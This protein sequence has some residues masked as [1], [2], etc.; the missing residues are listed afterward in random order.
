MYFR[1]WLSVLLLSSHAFTLEM[2]A[3]NLKG[4]SAAKSYL[5]GLAALPN[6]NS[7]KASYEQT[8]LHFEKAKNE[9]ATDKEQ[10]D[11]YHLS[12]LGLARVYYE[13]AFFLDDKDPQHHFFLRRAIAEYRSIPRFSPRWSEALFE[14]AWAY[15]MIEDYDGALGALYSLKDPYF[16]L[17]FFPE[18]NI[19]EAIIYLRNCHFEKAEQALQKF[20]SA[21]ASLLPDL[22]ILLQKKSGIWGEKNLQ[23][24]ISEIEALQIRAQIISLETKSA[25][26]KLLEEEK[27]ILPT[28][29]KMPSRPHVLGPDH[30]FWG[31]DRNERWI[32]ELGYYRISVKSLCYE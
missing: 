5:A 15:T 9:S 30:F 31:A 17:K 20:E 6:P 25:K 24:K 16:A 19:L 12:T 27:P 32:D 18:L 26:A 2:N 11:L 3:A 21:Y 14:Q 28:T 7:Q 10:T 23:S 29:E 13:I 1:L 8:L 22:K 4:S